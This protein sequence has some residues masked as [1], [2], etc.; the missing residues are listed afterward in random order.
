[1]SRHDGSITEELAEARGEYSQDPPSPA[2]L[3]PGDTVV[4]NA[5]LAAEETAYMARFRRST[6][7]NMV[8]NGWITDTRTEGQP[9]AQFQLTVFTSDGG[10]VPLD[11][12]TWG[13]AIDPPPMWSRTHPSVSM[14]YSN[15]WYP[16]AQAA[17]LSAREQLIA[18]GMSFGDEAP[19]VVGVRARIKAAAIR[20]NQD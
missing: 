9:A 14:E 10:T 8:L 7:G 2:E 16:N 1:M 5:T 17:M 6:K 13:I 18:G 12:W 4:Y 3:P 20:R 15:I 11:K 19:I